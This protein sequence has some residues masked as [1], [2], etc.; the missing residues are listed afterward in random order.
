MAKNKR[1]PPLQGGVVKKKKRVGQSPRVGE[2]IS[3]PLGA[4]PGSALKPL[5]SSDIQCA[6][7]FLKFCR[8][9]L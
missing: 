2:D 7:C 4:A 9:G 3:S 5:I 1:K 8:L 6:V